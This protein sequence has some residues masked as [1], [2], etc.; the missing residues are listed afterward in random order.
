MRTLGWGLALLLAAGCA[1]LP[2][3]APE[4]AAGPPAQFR[5]EGRISV[6]SEDQSFTGSI[7]WDH[8]PGRDEILLASPL[9]QGIAELRLEAGRAELVS[10]QGRTYTADNG[11]DLLEGVLGVRLPLSGMLHWLAGQPRP[12]APFELERGRDGRVVR[13]NQD[14]WHLEYG[15]YQHLGDYWLPGRIFARRDET[16]EFRL[17]VDAWRQP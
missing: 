4:P 6:R 15:R 17:V 8:T 10:A 2:P 13:L 14:G 12:Q 5:L 3:A 9:G 11:E 16:L 7:R 1:R